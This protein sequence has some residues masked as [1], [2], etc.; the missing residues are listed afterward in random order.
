MTDAP[1]RAVP[2]SVS[3]T[4]LMSQV[5]RLRDEGIPTRIDKHFLIGM[6]G[7]TQY[8]FRHGGFA[9]RFHHRGRSPYTAS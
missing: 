6:A 4:T 2:P 8:Q 7:G 1:A 5:D 9:P 3:H